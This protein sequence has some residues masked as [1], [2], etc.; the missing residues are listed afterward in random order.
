MTAGQHAAG[1]LLLRRILVGIP[2]L[3]GVVV[4]TFLLTR[5]LPGDPAAYFAGP[6]ATAA[7]IEEIRQRLGLD[8]GITDQFILYVRDL[9]R[10]DLGTSLLSGQPVLDDLLRRLPASLELT[11]L[12]L[13][14]ASGVGIPLGIAAALRPG[15]GIDGVCSVLAM[16]GQAVPTFFMGLILVF[17]FYYT[18]EW[19]PAPIG[20]L[21]IIYAPPRALTGFWSVDAALVGDIDLLGRVLA[22][23]VLPVV[24]LAFFGLGPLARMT[25]A[26]MLEVLASDFIRT[27]RAA[28]LP[29]R[30]VLW[31][32]AFRN[33]LIPVL[34][35]AGMVFSFLLGANVLVEKVF[36]WPGVGAYAIEAVLASDYAPVQGFVIAMAMLY[37]L[38][39]LA[40]DICSS[41]IDPRMSF[42][43]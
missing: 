30:M 8:R 31:T 34:G 15:S 5:A 9:V 27:A 26:S 7:S 37:L 23:L 29:H 25:R 24:T 13:M 18:L 10:G 28:G 39:N 6:A 19:A 3:V 12:A 43:E 17:V 42:D 21:D 40:I 2:S 41:I 16:I 1:T 36:G 4:A 33:A 11:L 22:Q 35:T 32:Y 38:V 14:L 20:R